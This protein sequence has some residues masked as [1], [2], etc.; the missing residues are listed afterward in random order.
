MDNNAMVSTEALKENLLEN[1]KLMGGWTED[2]RM[3]QFLRIGA[4]SVSRN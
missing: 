1:A 3:V 2:N 4:R